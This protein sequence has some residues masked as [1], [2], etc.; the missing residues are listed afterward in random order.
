MRDRGWACC[1]GICWGGAWS[2]PE[3]Y[4]RR[5]DREL[6]LRW[7]L[8]FLRLPERWGCLIGIGM[9]VPCGSMTRSMAARSMGPWPWI[10][11][12]AWDGGDV[13]R[14]GGGTMPPRICIC[15]CWRCCSCICCICC[16]WAICC[17]WCIWAICI[18]CA[19]ACDCCDGGRWAGMRVRIAL[20][21]SDQ[22]SDERGASDAS[23]DRTEPAG[24]TGDAGLTGET[25]PD[26][27]GMGAD[28]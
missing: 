19:W 8:D 26:R 23:S 24:L 17:I 15:I 25:G 16:I 14:C 22:R 27:A 12:G 2:G 9:G 6:W 1:A 11:I 5:P 18:C 13:R 28:R 4:L 20:P 10:W 21:I 7:L 3:T